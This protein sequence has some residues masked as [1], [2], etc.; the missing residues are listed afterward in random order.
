MISKNIVFKII[1]FLCV[2]GI[3]TCI[4]KTVDSEHVGDR[5]IDWLIITNNR[6]DLSNRNS[7]LNVW[8]TTIDDLNSSFSSV[9]SFG[10]TIK[11]LIAVLT[12]P[13]RLVLGM[14]NFVI[15]C[16]KVLFDFFRMVIFG[17]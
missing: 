17:G 10:D 6:F 12:A 3:L 4:F 14:I 7:V 9:E 1:G 5:L 2:V 16:F 13:V 11:A 8:Q 15:G